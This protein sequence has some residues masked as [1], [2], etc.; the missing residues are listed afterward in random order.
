MQRSNMLL[1]IADL[2]EASAEKIA[3]IETLDNGKPLR[4]SFPLFCL[5]GQNAGGGGD[6][7]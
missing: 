6:D 4:G 1:K 5:C 2:I 7:A 3:M